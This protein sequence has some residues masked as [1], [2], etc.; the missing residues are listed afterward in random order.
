MQK[1]NRKNKNKVKIIILGKKIFY[2]IRIIKIFYKYIMKIKKLY[3]SRKFKKKLY[4]FIIMMLII[5]K[6]IKFKVYIKSKFN[7][8]FIK[9]K[10]LNS[11]LYKI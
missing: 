10:S 3:L 8:N 6:I 2:N 7:L 9:S 5:N 11:E 1:N 4:L